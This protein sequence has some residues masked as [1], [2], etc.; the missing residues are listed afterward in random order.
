MRQ[1]EENFEK[2]QNLLA[3][4]RLDIPSADYFAG[5][6]SEFHY[7]QRIAILEKKPSL[8][9][10]FREWVESFAQPAVVARVAFAAIVVIASF[11]G[12]SELAQKSASPQYLS[13]QQHSVSPIIQDKSGFFVSDLDQKIDEL[14]LGGSGLDES[15]A[16]PH[17]VLNGAP[18]SYDSALAF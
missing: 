12:M 7:R 16:K 3:L 17:Y 10:R 11:A 8:A 6:L 5:T 18:T 9:D 14:T 2:L 15:S 4:K 13:L 1:K